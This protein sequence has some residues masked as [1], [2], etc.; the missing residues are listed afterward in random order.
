MFDTTSQPITRQRRRGALPLMELSRL[1]WYT[2]E[3]GG[4]RRFKREDLDRLL[5]PGADPANKDQTDD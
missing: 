5:R 2:F 4:R 1:S 3:P